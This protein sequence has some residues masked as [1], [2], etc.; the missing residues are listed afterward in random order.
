MTTQQ[1]PPAGWVEADL[2][3][4]IEADAQHLA[5]A[6]AAGHRVQAHELV[7]AI[8]DN[9]RDLEDRQRAG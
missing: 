5:N 1:T 9:S 3:V 8:I 6:L 7:D 4:M 2:K